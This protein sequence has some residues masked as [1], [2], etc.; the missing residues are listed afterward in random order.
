MFRSESRFGT[1]GA[2][3]P[4]PRADGGVGPR[5]EPSASGEHL[6]RGGRD[7][8]RPT[9]RGGGPGGRV[10]TR[11]GGS[12]PVPG[13]RAKSRREARK[14]ADGGSHARGREIRR[15]G[16]RIREPTRGRARTETSPSPRRRSS[17]RTW[18]PSRPALA[19]PLGR[20]P[21]AV[22]SD[23]SPCR[24][25]RRDWNRKGHEIVSNVPFSS[26]TG[27]DTR[28][29]IRARPRRVLGLDDDDV[30]P[31]CIDTIHR[32]LKVKVHLDALVRAPSPATLKVLSYVMI[33]SKREERFF[34]ASRR[35][36]G[37]ATAHAATPPP[38]L[39]RPFRSSFRNDTKPN[40]YL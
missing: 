10:E 4:R 6:A 7:A 9:A 18:P 31:T 20:V 27:G 38:S 12:R 29:G 1:Y 19:V 26:A 5:S 21:R 24:E 37:R 36:V 35:A 40:A 34:F 8:R 33:D 14:G 28:R 3:R 11:A 32:S 17:A 22:A 23:D 39:R 16:E 15:G 25:R 30:N 13:H 2:R